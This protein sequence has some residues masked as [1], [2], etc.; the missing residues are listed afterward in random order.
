MLQAEKWGSLGVEESQ[1][2]S[3]PRKNDRATALPSPAPVL[4]HL[5]LYRMCLLN[6]SQRLPIPEEILAHTELT[7]LWE[8][9]TGQLKSNN[10]QASMEGS[11]MVFKCGVSA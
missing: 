11:L 10:Y 5:W 7:V 9:E 8:L 4:A 6:M 3:T 2:L 1:L